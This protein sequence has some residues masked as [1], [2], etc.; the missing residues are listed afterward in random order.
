MVPND[1]GKRT[2]ENKFGRHGHTQATGAQTLLFVFTKNLGPL[3]LY[4][5]KSTFFFRVTLGSWQSRAEGRGSSYNLPTPTHSLPRPADP[6]FPHTRAGHLLQL[7]LHGPLL[8]PQSLELTWGLIL[9]GGTFRRLGQKCSNSHLSLWYQAELSHPPENTALHLLDSL[10]PWKPL[11]FFYSCIC[12]MW[13]FSGQR[14]N[15]CHSHNPSR[16]SDNARSLP[17]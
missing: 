17:P 8:I 15:P 2:E 14:L 7:N 6:H 1:V 4:F 9:G 11:I 5:F 13:K 16:C 3:Q 12:C 10:S